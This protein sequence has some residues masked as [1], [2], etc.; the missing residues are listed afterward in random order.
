[1]K[2]EHLQNKHIQTGAYL[3]IVPLEKT[4]EMNDLSAKILSSYQKKG[5]KSQIP[6]DQ[7]HIDLVTKLYRVSRIIAPCKI[8][9]DEGL[10]IPKSLVQREQ[11]ILADDTRREIKKLRNRLEE[12]REIIESLGEDDVTRAILN[13]YDGTENKILSFYDTIPGAHEVLEEACKFKVSR[14]PREYPSWHPRAIDLCKKFW[15]SKF[16]KPGTGNFK[17]A[18]NGTVAENDFSKW[19]SIIL[20]EAAE[21]EIQRCAELLSGRERALKKSK[22]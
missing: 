11:N 1:M 7:D 10:K 21:I 2:T 18:F 15:L 17:T 4:K 14:G 22:K 13:F 12:I 6:R 19:C 16:N 9:L 5:G 20:K 8:S 3:R